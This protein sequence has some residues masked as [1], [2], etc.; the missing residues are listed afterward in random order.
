MTVVSLAKNSQSS[1]IATE[2]PQQPVA[3]TSLFNCF[4]T[5]CIITRSNS[6]VESE[7][8]NG[9]IPH[10]ELL[11]LQHGK[12]ESIA[13]NIVLRRKP[14]LEGKGFSEFSRNIN[15]LAMHP[16]CIGEDYSWYSVANSECRS[17]TSSSGISIMSDEN[18]R[19]MQALTP[20]FMCM[21]AGVRAQDLGSELLYFV[22]DE[23]LSRA[24]AGLGFRFA[25]LSPK[26]A[27]NPSCAPCVL[28]LDLFRDDSHPLIGLFDG[29]R[30]MLN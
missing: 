9:I 1:S 15:D 26:G 4:I 29:I 7:N 22:A 3:L 20:L 19:R 10:V 13:S 2:K 28:R 21:V 6:P 8:A 11:D 23:R 27:G 12:I 18:V 25:R 24:L 30:T 5:E 16:S 17:P 14:S